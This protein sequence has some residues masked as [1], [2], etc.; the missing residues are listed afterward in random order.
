MTGA[1]RPSTARAVAAAL[2]AAHLLLLTRPDDVLRALAVP[3]PWPPRW[4]GRLLGARV[5]LQQAAVLRA[6]SRRLVIGGVVV[7]CLHAAS[8]VTAAVAWPQYRR[9]AGLS[10]AVATASAGLA[11]ATA[12]AR[13]ETAS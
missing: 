13:A 9:A 4:L 10:A 3:R 11:L 1:R 7:D 5:V 2:G 8:M 6:P 12:P